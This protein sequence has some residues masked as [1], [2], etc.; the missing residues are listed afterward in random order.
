M[1]IY[2]E[3]IS[4]RGAGGAEEEEHVR[5]SNRR[6]ETAKNTKDAK[7]FTAESVFLGVLGDLAVQF[8]IDR[9]ASK[10]L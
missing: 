6:N 1:I 8:A 2:P 7:Q 10:E 5:P 4:R 9:C 3:R